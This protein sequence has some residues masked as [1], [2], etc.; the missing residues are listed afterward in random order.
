MGVRI[1]LVIAAALVAA[2]CNGSS[3]VSPTSTGTVSSQPTTTAPPPPS[4]TQYAG[5]WRGNYIIDRCTGQGSMQD[6]FCSAPSGSRPGGIFP[7]GTSLPISMD[8]TQSGSSVSGR[9][10]F[11]TVCGPLSGVV[12]SGVLTLQGTTT[13]GQY[14]LRITWWSTRAQ[15]SVMDGFISYE[16]RYTGI[17]GNANVDT[18]LG[19]VQR[20]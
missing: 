8:L 1:G 15:S 3:P 16:A 6:L 19:L 5:M 18:R 4:V 11:G 10:C 9:V 7:V 12:S 20:E 14:S 13:G 2:A 17:P